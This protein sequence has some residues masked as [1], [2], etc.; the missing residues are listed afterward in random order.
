MPLQ[1]LRRTGSVRA[2]VLI[3]I[4][5]VVAVCVVD[6]LVPEDVHLGPLLV[7]APA[8]TAA[9]AGPGSPP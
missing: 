4:G 8:L 7:A 2:L 9:F 5:L 6:V 3:P 1:E